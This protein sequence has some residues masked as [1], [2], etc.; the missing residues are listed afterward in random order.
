MRNYLDFE[1]EIKSLEEEVDNLKS[2]F[3]SEGISQVDTEKIRNTQEQ[4]NE[5]LEKIYSNLNSW[6]KTLVARHEDRPR[7][8][9]YIRKIFS[10]FT[11]LS[12]DRYFGEDKSVTAGFG[13]IDNKSV[14]VIGQEKGEDLKGRIEK[15]FGMMK[16]EISR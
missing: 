7:A 9:F 6:Q 2:P 12:G 1:K 3:G 5:K 10:N 13:I 11:V 4:I 8:S 15:N 14:L 16:P